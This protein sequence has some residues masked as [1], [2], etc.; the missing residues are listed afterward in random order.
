VNLAPDTNFE[1]LVR[2]TTK[3]K[4]ALNAQLQRRRGSNA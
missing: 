3:P 2:L 1:P 4:F